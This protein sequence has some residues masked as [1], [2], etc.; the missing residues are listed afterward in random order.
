MYR[1]AFG[2]ISHETNTFCPPTTVDMFRERFWH[3]G[4]DLV[5]R[6]RGIRGYMGGMVEAAERLGV[7]LIPTFS[8]SAEPWGTI[9]R[10]AF[11]AMVGELLAG[12]RRA[13][14]TSTARRP[15]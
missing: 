7:T 12:L 5:R 3:S 14:P 11:T 13:A 8:A 1:I 10:E 15:T 2:G 9:T 4:D 6:V